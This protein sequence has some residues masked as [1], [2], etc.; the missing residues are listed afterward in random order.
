MVIKVATDTAIKSNT[1]NTILM[2]NFPRYITKVFVSIA[3]SNY[4]AYKISNENA[5]GKT[6]YG[7][8]MV[9]K[10]LLLTTKNQ[11]FKQIP[12][13]LNIFFINPFTKNATYY[14]A[15]FSIEN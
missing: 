6:D 13:P 1:N 5:E 10:I 8:S 2:N 14:S 3:T 11:L 4:S 9:E 7:T 12:K 15:A